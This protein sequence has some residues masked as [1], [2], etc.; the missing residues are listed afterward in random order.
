MGF[1]WC[2]FIRPSLWDGITGQHSE[3]LLLPIKHSW[4]CTLIPLCYC[5]TPTGVQISNR[6]S[7]FERKRKESGI[8]GILLSVDHP[9]PPL[10]TGYN[11]KGK[12]TDDHVEV[13]TLETGSERPRAR[14][15]SWRCFFGSS[16]NWKGEFGVRNAY[17]R[18]N[19]PAT[20][21]ITLFAALLRR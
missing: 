20:H 11:A 17:S 16:R 12:E 9:P 13:S 18:C 19:D 10:S 4:Y 5:A 3:I 2:R 14:E 1:C 6:L 15:A 21:I 7:Q 8:H